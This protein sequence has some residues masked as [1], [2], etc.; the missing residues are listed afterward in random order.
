LKT[1][2]CVVRNATDPAAQTLH[3]TAADC[4]AAAS[5]AVEALCV[6]HSDWIEVWNQDELVLKRRLSN[7]YPRSPYPASPRRASQHYPQESR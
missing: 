4:R 7:L 2:R 3:V 1:Y 6:G 5:A